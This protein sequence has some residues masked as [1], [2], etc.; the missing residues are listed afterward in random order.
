MAATRRPASGR[1]A[2]DTS[3]LGPAEV[4]MLWHARSE[5]PV[6]LMHVLAGHAGTSVVL[7]FWL[8]LFDYIHPGSNESHL[9]DCLGARATKQ[10]RQI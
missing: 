3:G 9:E 2:C 6:Q 4:D 8:S 5:C 10:P 1:Q 7:A